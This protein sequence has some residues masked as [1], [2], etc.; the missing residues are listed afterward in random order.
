MNLYI[1][2]GNKT[3]GPFSLDEMKEMIQCGKVSATTLAWH[4][5]VTEWAPVGCLLKDQLNFP[6]LPP[7]HPAF[8]QFPPAVQPIDVPLKTPGIGLTSFW[9]GILGVPFWFVLLMTAGVAHNA[10]AGDQSNIMI[11]VGL[12]IFV[13]LGANALGVML[14]GIA[15]N[16]RDSKQ[17]LSWIGTG[18]N[19]CEIL[20]LVALI[21]LGLSM[22]S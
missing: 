13:G 14:G 21:I 19:L 8:S 2:N 6:S 5:G 4:G 11:F 3:E 12:A 16:K 1:I 7:P 18:L 15:A 22:K 9:M 10:G 20:G 17:T